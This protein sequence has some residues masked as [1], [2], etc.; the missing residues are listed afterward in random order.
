[1]ADKVSFRSEKAFQRA[2]EKECRR[3]GW[4]FYHVHD[5]RTVSSKEGHGFPDLVIM[6][7]P[8]LMFVELKLSS[9][10]TSPDQVR[11]LSGLKRCGQVSFVLT[12]DRFPQFINTLKHS[13]TKVE[14]FITL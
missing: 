9:N 6:R 10:R 11:W 5:S 2:V 3:L 4:Q 12:P 7:P 8:C 14:K 1:M 13:T